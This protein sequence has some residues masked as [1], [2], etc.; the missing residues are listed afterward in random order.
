MS[1]YYRRRTYTRVVKPKK[2]W[3]SNYYE[4]SGDV[5]S[6]GDGQSFWYAKP[7]GRNT[8]EVNSPTPVIVKTGNFRVQF[9]LTISVG[10][11]G[12][13]AA[14]AFVIFVPQG[15]PS[16]TID[17][18]QN[19]VKDH[20][21]WIMVWRQLDFGNANAA[22]TYDT[23]VVKMSSRLKRNLNSGDSVIFLILG[24]GDFTNVTYKAKIAG[25]AQYWTCAN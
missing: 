15:W 13:I 9:D 10:A 19:I 21:E 16:T 22:G 3:A 25:A 14:R 12:A 24:T 2:K 18:Y 20:P 1:R 5:Q 11:S 23:S 4:L 7:L 8:T 17:N 6:A